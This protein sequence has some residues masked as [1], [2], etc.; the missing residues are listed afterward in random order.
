MSLPEQTRRDKPLS[1]RWR[2]LDPAWPVFLD[3][4]P[5]P[6]TEAERA[7]NA[8]ILDAV[9]EAVGRGRWISYSRRRTFYTGQRRYH[10]AAYT[11]PTV[12]GNVDLLTDTG[13]LEHEKASG[14]GPTGWQSR[15]RAS[16]RLLKTPPPLVLCDPGELV[17]LKHG[18]DLV[19]YRDTERTRRWRRHV[20]Q[21]NEAIG[22]AVLDIDAP[23]QVRDGNV[24][25]FGGHAIYPAM[26]S[27]YRVFNDSWIQ[28]GRAYGLGWQ[29]AKKRDREYITIDGAAT[30]ERDYEQLHP[31]LLYRLAGEDLAGDAYTLDGVER[32]LGKKAF[33]ILV[34]AKTYPSAVKA[35]ANEIGGAGAHAKARD[36]VDA[37][38][39]RHRPI[40]RY[41]HSGEGLRLQ[42]IDAGMAEDVMLSLLKQ[43][44]VALPIHDSFIVQD[45]HRGRL[46][47]A[48]DDAFERAA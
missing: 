26:Q 45:R 12:V 16:P 14:G 6:S 24:I 3:L 22:A 4:P 37:M 20:E 29:Q 11:Y 42:N 17:R 27:L 31:R 43:G 39:R 21:M 13:L 25:R 2:S 48:M 23:G 34:N 28:G 46:E 19:D 32:D 35:L 38:K 18:D 7:R 40:E 9:L 36:L 8:I 1:F 30:V 10:G 44:V 47:E 5:A 33:N 41:F 15:F